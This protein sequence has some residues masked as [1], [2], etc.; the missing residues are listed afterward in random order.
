MQRDELLKELMELD[1]IAIDMSLYLDT[2]NDNQK[3]LNEYNNV[4]KAADVVRT[5]YESE[6]GP[7]CSFRSMQPDGW[8]WVDNPWPWQKELNFEMSEGGYR[9]VDL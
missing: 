5:K 2:H 7:L 4:I 9:N 3:A 8:K 1:F 6:N